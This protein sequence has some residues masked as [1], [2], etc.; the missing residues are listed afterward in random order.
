MFFSWPTIYPYILNNCVP[1][2]SVPKSFRHGSLWDRLPRPFVAIM[3][4]GIMLVIV[5]FNTII[6]PFTLADNRHYVFYVFRILLRHPLIKYLAVPV[7]FVCGWAAIAALGG[8]PQTPHQ[9]PETVPREK[10]AKTEES[11]SRKV[12][13]RAEQDGGVR[14]SFVLVWLASTALSLIMA[15]LVEPR[16]FIIPWIMWRLH[17]PSLPASS[18]PASSVAPRGLTRGQKIR[19]SL[20]DHDHRLW[21]ETV[22]L[23]IINWVTGYV[24]LHKGFEWPQEPGKV[25][26][27]M[28]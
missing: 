2:A 16:Y 7:Y 14:V 5:H 6:H 4:T 10:R 21:I 20:R 25:Q 15:P 19:N 28:W 8:M 18:A 22:W 26:R 27:F 12:S 23:L 1:Q 17:V 13:K 9:S 24:F 11:E 3:I